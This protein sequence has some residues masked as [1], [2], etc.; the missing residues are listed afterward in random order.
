VVFGLSMAR[1]ADHAVE[2]AVLSRGIQALRNHLSAAKEADQQAYLLYA[3]S[4]AGVRVDEVRSQ[5]T[6]K[7][8]E[9]KP[10]SKAL[11]ALVLAKDG[12]DAKFVVDALAK[13]AKVVGG[14]VFFEGGTNGGW[15]DH[16]MEVTAAALRAFLK[17]EPK[18]ELV[19]RMVH[20]LSL[21]RQGNYW[22]STKQTAMVVFSLVEYL[23]HTGDLNPDMTLTL[24]VNG[25]RIFSERV[26][27]DNW[28]EF[29]GMRKFKA[30][31]LREGENEVVIEKTGNGSPIWS[32]Y[33]KTYAEAEN[34]QPSQGGIQV[35]RI[36]SK[37]I[38]EAGQ[39]VLQRLE[40][41][42]TVTSGDEIEVMITVTADRN[43]EW[44][45][46]D[47]PMPSGFEAIRE[48]WGHYGWGR[49]AYWYSRKEFRDEKVSVAMS[50]LWQGKH[51][52]AY[53][54]RAETPGDFHVL[55]TQV[56]NMY[57]PEIGGNAGEF[58]IKVV[59]KK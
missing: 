32:I 57:H 53:V 29:E 6:D 38:R 15:M 1:D 8:G 22:G 19:P 16:Q 14:S 37:V 56:F 5:L 30:A 39:R 21:V 28:H 7:L 48:H 46:M 23:A 18:H 47:D 13:D 55:P 24:T 4:V 45:M 58:R 26:T 31:K 3:L 20:W 49:W 35:E 2:P 12:R 25:E 54:M 17:V 41:G 43:Y 33:T 44:L 36:Y 27:K 34:L 50:T 40:S 59:D 10:Y 42:D 52:V 51:Q 11:L 9:L